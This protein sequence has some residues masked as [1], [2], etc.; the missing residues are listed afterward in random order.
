[1]FWPATNEDSITILLARPVGCPLQIFR[2]DSAQV[3]EYNNLD[4]FIFQSL[5]NKRILVVME[6]PQPSVILSGVWEEVRNYASRSGNLKVIRRQLTDKDVLDVLAYSAHVAISILEASVSQGSWDTVFPGRTSWLALEYLRRVRQT[7]FPHINIRTII[8]SGSLDS[9]TCRL[10]GSP[11][12]RD[13]NPADA[14]VI[15]VNRQVR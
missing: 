7:G 6:P 10:S 4:L 2:I 3:S 9:F 14:A 1:M 13:F 15:N 8:P 11:S 12:M 5:E